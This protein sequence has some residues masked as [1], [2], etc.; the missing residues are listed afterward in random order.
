[1]GTQSTECEQGQ[2]SGTIGQHH[3]ATLVL[4]CINYVRWWRGGGGE[5]V[6]I[7]CYHIWKHQI[8]KAC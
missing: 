3:V 6:R 5:G 8:E 2:T 7:G 1:M 4:G